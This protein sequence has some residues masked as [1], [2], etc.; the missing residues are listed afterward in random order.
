[1]RGRD[2]Q[3]RPRLSEI[4]RRSTE[5]P[6]RDDPLLSDADGGPG[7][8]ECWQHD[9]HRHYGDYHGDNYEDSNLDGGGGE[10]WV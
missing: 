10:E 8:D 9:D 3:A 7:C 5:Q 4:L 2:G 1:M 6:W